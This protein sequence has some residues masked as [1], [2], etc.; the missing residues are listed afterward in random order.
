MG[1]AG[2]FLGGWG[3]EGEGWQVFGQWEKVPCEGT[4]GAGNVGHGTDRVY[5]RHSSGGSSSRLETVQC[6]NA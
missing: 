3:G 2:W 5:G 1:Q 4:A 6:T